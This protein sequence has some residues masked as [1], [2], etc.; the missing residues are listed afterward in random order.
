MIP[1]GKK[2]EANKFI[3]FPIKGA[4]AVN[5]ARQMLM[6]AYD[7]SSQA[8]LTLF[9]RSGNPIAQLSLPAGQT[10]RGIAPGG[11]SK[12]GFFILTSGGQ[13]LQV[14]A[15]NRQLRIAGDMGKTPGAFAIA[16]GPKGEVY[17]ATKSGNIFVFKNGAWV[18]KKIG[19]ANVREITAL[20]VDPKTG[21][22]VVLGRV[23]GS[24]RINI[25]RADSNL[26][27]ARAFELPEG[28]SG[29]ASLV[30][31][32][33]KTTVAYRQNGTMQMGMFDEGGSLTGT[34]PVSSVS[35]MTADPE[36]G[37][38]W[39]V[40]PSGQMTRQDVEE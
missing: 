5:G 39:T 31:V 27:G 32:N 12:N 7:Q 10:P 1:F 30:S 40:G 4:T 28:S 26:G 38:V 24:S 8:G 21:E 33:G 34:Q 29:A 17:A 20:T 19:G 25:V 9:D 37:S 13:I 23:E 22:V 3:G 35:S 15:R 6:A 16:A 11:N 14:D 36:T 18:P 2:T